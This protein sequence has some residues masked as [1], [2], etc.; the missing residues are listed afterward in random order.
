MMWP[1]E[2]KKC[3]WPA[4]TGSGEEGVSPPEPPE[5]AGLGGDL[6]SGLLACRSVRK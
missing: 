4:E 6:Q 3:Q 1:Q 5:G 2:I